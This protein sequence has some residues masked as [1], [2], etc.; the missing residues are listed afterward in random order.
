MPSRVS[1]NLRAIYTCMNR[2]IKITL[3]SCVAT[4]AFAAGANAVSIGLN[5]TDGWPTPLLAGETADG[6]SNWTDSMAN[7]G[8]GGPN[9]QLG[10]ITLLGGSVTATWNSANTW[11]GGNEAT[12]EQQL[13]RVYLDDG[14][15]GSSLVNGDGIGV[16]V[17]ISGLSAWMAANGGLSYR[18]RCYAS[19]DQDNAL[20]QPVL[21]RSGAPNAAD[22]ANQ[23]LN[24]GILDTVTVPVLGPG[25]FPPNTTPD[26]TWGMWQPRGFG[27]SSFTLTDDVIT[28][29]IAARNGSTRG[30]LAG[31]KIDLIPEPSSLALLAI[32]LGALI[33]RRGRHAC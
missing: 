3:V 20:F 30:T 15:G 4:V 10:S 23:L 26:P 14:D 6:F 24:L 21:I 28:L 7:Y 12:S 29:T 16:S 31:F 1:G 27:D 11:A 33:V 18:I 32:G 8:G 2:S 19:T 13:Y 9:P 22:G 17:T 25:D 5:I